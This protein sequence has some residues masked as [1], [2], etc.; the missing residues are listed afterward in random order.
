MFP[1]I[2]IALSVGGV[3]G[4][5]TFLI[6]FHLQREQVSFS[7]HHTVQCGISDTKLAVHSHIVEQ[8]GKQKLS[9]LGIR[10]QLE[11]GMDREGSQ[12][13]EAFSV[14]EEDSHSS[15]STLYFML[16]RSQLL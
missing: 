2:L 4:A 1:H 16:P 11:M 7:W 6:W 14:Y 8:Q 13:G 12:W 10:K 9:D 5:A 15:C 3:G